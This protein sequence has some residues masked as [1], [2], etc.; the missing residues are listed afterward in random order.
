MAALSRLRLRQVALVAADLGAAERAIESG[1]GV[2]LC[3]RDPGVGVFGL[4]NAL[5]PIGEQLL[6]VVSPV[7]PGTTAGRYLER[8]GGDGGYMVILE[9]DEPLDRL[10]GRLAELGVRVVFEAIVPGI[11]G[12]HLH[13]R[14]VG[15]A[16]LSID[17]TDRWGEWP[18][19]G[20]DW[21]SHVRTDLVTGIAAVHVGA[22][23]PHAMAQRWAAVLER[24]V[25]DDGSSI[26]LDEGV[27]RFVQV[28]PVRGEG[29]DVIELTGAPGTAGFATRIAGCEVLIRPQ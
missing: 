1:F 20:P 23:D 29:V 17:R 19:A 8:R 21:R 16:I 5:F 6:E 14:D 2:E 28:D 13:P 3:F 26:P 15:G 18:W 22:V 27:I 24:Q 12:L 11:T 7:E 25:G 9:T 4:H 10:R